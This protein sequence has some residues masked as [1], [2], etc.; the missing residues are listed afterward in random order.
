M[1]P[2]ELISN[3]FHAINK[4]PVEHCALIVVQ[5]NQ[6]ESGAECRRVVAGSLDALDSLDRQRFP[7]KLGDVIVQPAR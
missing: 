5:R 3:R 4:P 1:K 2:L 7:P 6:T